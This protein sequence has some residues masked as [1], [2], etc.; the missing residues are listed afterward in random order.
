[1]G[2][3]HPVR[4]YQGGTMNLLRSGTRNLSGYTALWTEA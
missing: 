3:G 2:R 1:M 4:W